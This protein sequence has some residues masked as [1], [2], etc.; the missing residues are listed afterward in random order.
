M[1]RERKRSRS[2]QGLSLIE[3]LAVIAII[4]VFLSMMIPAILNARLAAKRSQCVNNLKQIVLA[5]H[6]YEDTHMSLP[7]GVVNPTGPIEDPGPDPKASLSSVQIGWMVQIL[8]YLEQSMM[9]RAFDT[10]LSVYS[11]A[12][13][14]VR[15]S[16]MNSALCPVDR[17][18]PFYFTSSSTAAP[19]PTTV[20]VSSYAGCHNDVEAAIDVNNRGVLYLNSHIRQQDVYDGTSSTIYVGEKLIANDDLGWA[21]GTRASLRNTGSPLNASAQGKAGDRRFVGGFSSGHPGGANA[22]FG[23]GSVH[24]LNNTIAPQVL[25]NLGN[26][27]DGEMIEDGR[28]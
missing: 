16:H 12:N 10:R 11:E 18:T 25:R 9:W 4:S 27:D 15:H 22:A 17:P 24:F 23:D 20:G 2:R 6:N 28:Y 7:P 5:L 26:R 3:F 13:S 21:S 14:T 19:V 1:Q 8:P